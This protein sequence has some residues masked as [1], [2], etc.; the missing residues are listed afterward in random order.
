MHPD[1]EAA[2]EEMY[3][4]FA[5]PRPRAID[6]CT[7]CCFTEKELRTLV[8][9]P[10]RELTAE[11]LWE[12]AFSALLTAGDENDLRYFWPRIVELSARG[13]LGVDLEI[14]FEKPRRGE[15]RTWPQREQDAIERFARAQMADLARREYDFD[16]VDGW[17]C[18]F[19]RLFEDVMPLLEPLLEPT[20]AA[21]VNL[22]GLYSYN[23]RRAAR[24]T[25]SNSFWDEGS[26]NERRIAAWLCSD[27]VG[28]ALGRYYAEYAP[29]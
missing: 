25:L 27:P 21:T 22:F 2:V 1:I 14:V 10:L 17:V 20:R 19:G 29:D 6:A 24:G 28:E 26:E 8:E 3:A 12:Y 11:Q 7:V 5:R 23:A 16:E 4:A 15:W 18:G 9:T 13:E